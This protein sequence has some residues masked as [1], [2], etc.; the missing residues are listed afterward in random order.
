MAFCLRAL[1][2]AIKQPISYVYDHVFKKIGVLAQRQ[3]TE[4]NSTEERS[5]LR[6]SVCRILQAME[7]IRIQE[8]QVAPGMGASCRGSQH[9]PKEPVRHMPTP[10]RVTAKNATDGWC[11]LS[12][13][14]YRILQEM[15]AGK[16]RPRV[17][18][19]PRLRLAASPA[20]KRQPAPSVAAL[21]STAT[22]KAHVAVTGGKG[23][24]GWCGLSGCSSRVLQALE[25]MQGPKEKA[26]HPQVVINKNRKEGRFQ[27]L[28]CLRKLDEE[29]PQSPALPTTPR[30][31]TP[32]QPLPPP[33]S[34]PVLQSTA[35]SLKSTGDV[36]PKE[37]ALHPQVVINNNRKEGRFQILK[38]LR[39]LDEETPQRP[40]L[41]TSPRQ[42]TTPQ[43]LPAPPS[44]P[45]PSSTAGSF[46]SPGYVGPKE[47][48][49]HLQVV[50]NKNW[51]EGRFQILRCL[52]KLDEET[53]QRPG[54]PTSPR[55]ST[56][57]QPL[58]APPS[59]PVTP[60]TAGS[61]EST[62]D[63]ETPQRPGLPTS[64]RQSTPPQPLPAPPSVAVPSSTAGSFESPGYVG[65]KEKAVHLQVV[66]NKNWKKGRFQILRCLR[67][68]DE[69]TPQR[70][71]LPTSPRLSTP[72]QPL[73]APPSA[74][75]TPSTAGSIESTRDVETPQRPGLPT[76]P[77][78]S[79]PPQPLPAPP[80]VAVPS[81]TAGSFE[82][83]GYV[84]PKE[85]AVHLQVVVNKNWKK[86]RFQ[87]LR[88]LR[89][90]DEETP[91]RPGL[92][93]S[94]RLSTPS[95]PLPAPPSAPVTPS[96]AG[97]IESTRDVET[98]QR[99]GLPTSPRRSTPPQ[100]LPAPPSV[101][102]PS[103][104]AGS[105]ESPGYVGPKEKAVHLQ[106]V[107]NKNWKKGRFQVL[108]CLRKLDE[109]T[110][111]RPG[112]PTS[113]RRSTPPQPLPA[114][115]SVPVPSSTAGSFESPGYV[116]KNWNRGRPDNAGGGPIR[117][118]ARFKAR[119]SW[120]Q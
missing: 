67:K 100:P 8:P 13:S 84:G 6:S 46:E 29:T 81:S 16:Y 82:S 72:S 60:S 83:P 38:C 23:T 39:K 32:P 95:Q 115:P 91:Q 58:P 40:G 45:V 30:L 87:I 111:Q 78:Q 117:C 51:K 15:E 25:A 19:P 77:R 107:V 92:P 86:G 65:P 108:R 103:S 102:V 94:P 53:P 76:S 74:P 96:T 27:I 54:L 4:T 11:G 55:L 71:G 79:T 56:P 42:S 17:M 118:A 116:D 47:K 21:P 114:P 99:P 119:R 41:P 24:K 109:E 63:V 73:P 93:T 36:R 33:P 5:V 98:P 9:R 64:P 28:K 31:S 7:A 35:G 43:P 105:F 48:A 106:V 89:K 59:A 104:T 97:S 101:A 2:L 110:P 70:P 57:S 62:R 14:T 120:P 22:K 20:P 10:I 34:A 112:L 69:E 3:D 37:K 18:P 85:K 68:L 49:V 75:V 90:L 66:V 12:T 26:L 80:S 44:V 52:R 88:C 1:A 50:V 113:P 61:I